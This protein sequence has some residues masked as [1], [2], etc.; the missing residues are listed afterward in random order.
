[1]MPTTSRRCAT[2]RCR[3]PNKPSAT[4]PVSSRAGRRD[5]PAKEGASASTRQGR[6]KAPGGASSRHA[7]L[8]H[9][10]ARA[11]KTTTLNTKALVDL[12]RGSDAAPV[13][14]RKRVVRQGLGHGRLDQLGC[15]AEPHAVEPGNDLGGFALGGWEI[16]LGVNGLQHQRHLAQLASRH[17]AEDVAIEVHH[18]ALPAR[19]GEVLRY[20]LDQA[21]AGVGDDQLDAAQAAFLEM[22][23]KAAP[24]GLVLLGALDDA[25]D[26]AVAL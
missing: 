21:H 8:R 22:A 4:T 9:E 19:L 16:L 5:H 14:L 20:A 10:V 6:S 3:S 26:L 7:A 15:F 13:L 24:A 12:I 18:A 2:R 17:M 25:E 1:P 23:Q 11:R